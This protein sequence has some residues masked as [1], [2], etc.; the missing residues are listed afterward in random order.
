MMVRRIVLEPVGDAWT[1]REIGKAGATTYASG[2][3]AERAARALGERLAGE[4]AFAHVKIMLRDG[5]VGGRYF[6]APNGDGPSRGAA[7]PL[8]AAA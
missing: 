8:L 5:K 2:A 1:V 4:G 3:Q 6:Y 7:R